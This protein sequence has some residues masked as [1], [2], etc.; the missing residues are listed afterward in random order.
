MRQQGLRAFLTAGVI[1]G[2][3]ALVIP[4][5]VARAA[6]PLREQSVLDKLNQPTNAVTRV[7]ANG[8]FIKTKTDSEGKVTTKEAYKVPLRI[9]ANV[10]T[11]TTSIRLYFAKG[12][13][14]LGWED[15]PGELR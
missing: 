10:R 15:N 4:V 5:P 9:T 8:L 13:V 6:S 11:D 2:A 1:A 7:G 12:V 3:A 14:I